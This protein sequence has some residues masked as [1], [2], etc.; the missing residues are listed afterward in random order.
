MEDLCYFMQKK[1][2]LKI[3]NKLNKFL[4]VPFR[5]DYTGSQIIYYSNNIS[6]CRIRLCERIKF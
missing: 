2:H 3:L 1:N 5:F 6:L 4:Y